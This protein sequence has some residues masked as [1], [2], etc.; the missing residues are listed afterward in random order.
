MKV[1]FLLFL[2]FLTAFLAEC[3][4][5]E[6]TGK[7]AYDYIGNLTQKTRSADYSVVT[8]K[9]HYPDPRTASDTDALIFNPL[10]NKYKFIRRQDSDQR[11]KL[12]VTEG[13]IA[14]KATEG[15]IPGYERLI[16]ENKLK[17]SVILDGQD[18]EVC[19]VYCGLDP[20][21]IL[22][23][24]NKKGEILLDIKQRLIENTP[25]GSDFLDRQ[26]GAAE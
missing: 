12:N 18:K 16:K 24:K 25:I 7:T 23:H 1:K 21:Y 15:K 11:L 19:I 10:G 14:E 3:P 8:L 4:A 9:R 5:K 22:W 2:F 20:C 6:L 13:S 17:P 26:S